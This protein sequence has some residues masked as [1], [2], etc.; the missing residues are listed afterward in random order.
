MRAA[1][2]TNVL[3]SGLLGLQGPGGTYSPPSQ[4]VRAVAAGQ[5]RLLLC[6]DILAEYHAV[7][8]RP[9]LRLQPGHVADLLGLVAQTAEWVPVLPYSGLPPL[10]DPSDW[11]F[12]AAA[13]L[14]DC[15]LI[16]GNLKHFPARLGVRV[17]SAREWVAGA[18]QT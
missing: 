2:D 7:L 17:V 1:V 10:P 12:I 6:D 13:R 4:V 14:G 18:A 5:L 11:P 9:R 8:R 16:T 15:P 3:V